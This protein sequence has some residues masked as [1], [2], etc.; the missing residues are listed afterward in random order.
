MKVGGGLMDV[1]HGDMFEVMHIIFFLSR[2]AAAVVV[3]PWVNE[4][5]ILGYNTEYY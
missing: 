5:R 2:L 3:V 4:A 1:L